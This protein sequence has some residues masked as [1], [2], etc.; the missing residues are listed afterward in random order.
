MVCG[1]CGFTRTGFIMTVSAANTARL[2][3]NVAMLQQVG[4]NTQVITAQ[5]LQE[6]QP[7]CQVNDLVVL[8]TSRRAGTLIRGRR[9]L[10]SCNG[11]SSRA[12]YCKKASW[13]PVY[14]PLGDASWESTQRGSIDAPIVVVMAG[15]WSDRL[16]KTAG[17]TF[18]ITTQRAQIAFYQRPA[19]LTQGHMVFIDGAIGTYFRPHGQDLTLIGVGQ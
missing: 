12:P 17:I 13:S 11:R 18:P 4:V 7:A 6:L 5:E 19:A 2:R 9:L 8:P 15:P 10:P 16:L 14:A 1:A 3:H